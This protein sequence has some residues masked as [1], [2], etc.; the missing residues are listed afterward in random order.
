MNILDRMMIKHKNIENNPNLG[1]YTK[2]KSN[3]FE[4]IEDKLVALD[5]TN[6]VN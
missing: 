2:Y 6:E 5:I 3:K 1:S 4:S